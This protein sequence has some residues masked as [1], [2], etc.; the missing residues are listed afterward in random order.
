MH[1]GIR[2]NPGSR[3]VGL[4]VIGGL[5]V[6]AGG[7]AHAQAGPVTPLP[8]WP[9]QTGDIVTSSP[10]LGDLDGDGALDVVVGSGDNNIY[11]WTTGPLE[12]TKARLE[13]DGRRPGSA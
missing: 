8:G 9:Q 10:A 3:G 13:S 12:A 4:V 2:H 5:M 6:L 1:A 7:V 11:A